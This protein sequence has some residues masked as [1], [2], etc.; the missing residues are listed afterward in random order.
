M[1]GRLIAFEG[2][3]TAGKSTVINILKQ[4]LPIIYGTKVK[5]IFSRE[6]GNTLNGLNNKCE[7]IRK[8]LLTDK[9]L[10]TEE[11]AKLFAESRYLHTKEIIEYIKKGYIVI[12]DRYLLSSLVYQGNILGLEKV[13]GYNLKSIDLLEENNITLNNVILNIDEE[14]FKKR[15]ANKSKDAMEDVSHSEAIKRID[16]YNFLSNNA[17]YAFGKVYSI[18]STQKPEK[19][20]AD[21]LNCLTNII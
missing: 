12:V 1:L 16:Q 6:P 10:T 2:P 11:Q 20:I 3:D 13:V 15:M 18:D 8:K 21:V 4:V 17:L 9:S 19:V 5:F 7:D 14:T